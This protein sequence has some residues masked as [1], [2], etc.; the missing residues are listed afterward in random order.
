MHL[1]T[2]RGR[3]GASRVA[4]G[5]G[6]KSAVGGEGGGPEPSPRGRQ[7]QRRCRPPPPVSIGFA[8]HTQPQPRQHKRSQTP[9]HG[10]VWHALRSRYFRYCSSAAPRRRRNS[11]VYLRRQLLGG[12]VAVTSPVLIS[13]CCKRSNSENLTWRGGRQRGRRGRTCVCVWGG[14]VGLRERGGGGMLALGGSE[15]MR[16]IHWG[17]H[18]PSS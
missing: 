2:R 7:R 15:T 11:G 1:C 4:P 5:G 10:R 16:Q 3:A 13:A 9:A 6:V 18:G 12:S 8:A 17:T 14:G